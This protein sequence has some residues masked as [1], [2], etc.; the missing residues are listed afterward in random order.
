MEISFQG[1]VGLVTGCKSPGDF[2]AHPL[3]KAHGAT[4]HVFLHVFFM[5]GHQNLHLTRCRVFTKP[6]CT[7]VFESW[8]LYKIGG[9]WLAG[10]S[11]LL[12]QARPSC[13]ETSSLWPVNHW[14]SNRAIFIAWLRS[15]VKLSLALFYVMFAGAAIWLEG[16]MEFTTALFGAVIL[17]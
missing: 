16:I 7:V 6:K 1:A 10:Q 8:L 5:F 17:R 4:S 12:T 15:S 11:L 3:A 9:L 13:K 14:S 2:L